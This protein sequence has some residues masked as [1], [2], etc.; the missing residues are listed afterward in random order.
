MIHQP[1]SIEELVQ[2]PNIYMA[3]DCLVWPQREV[4][5]IHERLEVLG[6]GEACWGWGTSS[7]RQRRKRN[8]IR[9]VDLEE[10]NIWTVNK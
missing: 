10:G 3:E 9:E 1:G 8:D 2:G 5:I 4:H 7:W 6:G